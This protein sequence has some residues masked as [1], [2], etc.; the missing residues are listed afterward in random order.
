MNLEFLSDIVGPDPEQLENLESVKKLENG[1][2]IEHIGEMK[3][4]YGGP[5][6]IMDHLKRTEIAGNPEADM[7]N[8]HMQGENNSCA[9][10][11]QEFIAEQLL[12]REFTEEELSNL[13]MQ[14]GW[15]DP[16]SGTSVSD[17]GNILEELGLTVERQNNVSLAELSQMLECGEKVICGVNNMILANPEMA[18]LPGMSANHAV[19]VIGIDSTDP[20]NIQVILNDPGVPDGCGIRHSISTFMTAWN[21]SGNYVV[22]AEKE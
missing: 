18:N 3:E 9:V 4:E 10:V 13:A 11:C 8:W 12:D 6:N 19:Q 20:N 17:V 7:E 5:E 15:Y 16:A 22:S 21:T 2:Y 1:V 14:R